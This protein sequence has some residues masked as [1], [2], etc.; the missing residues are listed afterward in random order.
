LDYDAGVR[1]RHELECGLR[2]AHQTFQS[3]SEGPARVEALQRLDGLSSIAERQ[4][5]IAPTP[6][7]TA[8][9]AAAV[10]DLQPWCREAELW[11]A[12]RLGYRA[13][14]PRPAPSPL[15]DTR[16]VLAGAAATPEPTTPTAP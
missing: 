15:C 14:E 8:I 12:D 3:L 5:A 10:G 9:A 11:K 16:P 13:S 6:S 4:L 2:E 1:I 7:A